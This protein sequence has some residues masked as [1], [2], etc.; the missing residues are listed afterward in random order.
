MQRLAVS[1]YCPVV[2]GIISYLYKNMWS[3]DY[4][5]ENRL[6]YTSLINTVLLLNDRSI[7]WSYKRFVYPTCEATTADVKKYTIRIIVRELKCVLSG[8]QLYSV[9]KSGVCR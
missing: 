9:I 8:Y 3:V 1:F 6:Y 7:I 2:A 5:N 4:P